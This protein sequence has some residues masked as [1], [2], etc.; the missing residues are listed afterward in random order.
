[1]RLPDKV[2]EVVHQAISLQERSILSYVN[3][4]A[5]TP[6]DAK[7]AGV[8]PFNSVI[9]TGPEA[10]LHVRLKGLPVVILLNFKFVKISNAAK[11][12][13]LAKRPAPTAAADSPKVCFCF[14]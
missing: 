3:S 12:P 6:A 5:I 1:M 14:S 10:S 4:L 13:K 7:K 2:S 9:S 11:P 8:A